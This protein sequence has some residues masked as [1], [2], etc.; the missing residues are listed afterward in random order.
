MASCGHLG[1]LLAYDGHPTTYSLYFFIW[2]PVS[3]AKWTPPPP[4]LSSPIPSFLWYRWSALGHSHLVLFTIVCYWYFFSSKR[5][6]A[7][8]GQGFCLLVFYAFIMLTVLST[9]CPPATRPHTSNS[10]T[11][12]KHFFLKLRELCLFHLPHSELGATKVRWA[13]Q[14]VPS[15]S[16][17]YLL[18][19]HYW[20]SKAPV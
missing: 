6:K 10:Y 5:P 11:W 1:L 18:A 2:G 19:S 15:S 14:N 16:Q 12:S 8:W 9:W 3:P 13:K 7:L 17:G 4:T 20:S